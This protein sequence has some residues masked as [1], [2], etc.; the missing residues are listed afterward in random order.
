MSG[1][2]STIIYVYPRVR[3]R[4]IRA[5]CHCSIS[6]CANYNA[7]RPHALLRSPLLIRPTPLN[8]PACGTKRGRY[9][10]MVIPNH[11]KLFTGHRLGRGTIT[12]APSRSTPTSS[13][14]PRSSVWRPVRPLAVRESVLPDSITTTHSRAAPRASPLWRTTAISALRPPLVLLLPRLEVQFALTASGLH[15]SLSALRYGQRRDDRPACT[16]D[17]G[18]LDEGTCLGLDDLDLGHLTEARGDLAIDQFGS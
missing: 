14:T 6:R 3:E 11:S 7:R 16:L 15:S 5:I 13:S 2:V 4:V 9:H 8:V 17:F 10:N 12:A 1:T 18:K